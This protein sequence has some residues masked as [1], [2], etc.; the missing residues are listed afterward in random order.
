MTRYD[1]LKK[2]FGKVLENTAYRRSISDV[3][4]D[5]AAMY[6]IALSNQCFYRQDYE[7][8]YLRI[9]KKYNSQEMA[10]LAELAGIVAFAVNECGFTDFLGDCFM[11]YG[12][13]TKDKG[14][15][16]TPYHICQLMADIT[17]TKDHIEP[18]IKEKGFVSIMDTACG[19][20][21]LPIA[22]V[23]AFVKLG[24]DKSQALVVANDLDR[25]CALCSYIQLSLLGVPAVVTVGDGLTNEKSEVFYTLRY[26]MNKDKF[27]EQETQPTTP[28]QAGQLSL[29]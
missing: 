14:Q 20:C 13:G 24:Y 2:K 10:G 27:E 17:M 29:F 11:C 21:A 3:F 19:C 22:G 12:F 6:A 25:R 4:T 26:L 15:F 28:A 8:E 23:E 7:D 18:I 5:W 1:E 9:E 16:F